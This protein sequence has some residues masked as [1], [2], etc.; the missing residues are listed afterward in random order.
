FAAAAAGFVRGAGAGVVVLPRLPAAVRAGAP[1]LAVV[2][3]SAVPPAGRSPGVPAPPPAA[4]CAVLAA[5][6][7]SGAVAP[8]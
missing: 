3:G 8:A 4:P 2:R 5:A 7:R 1:V 6:L